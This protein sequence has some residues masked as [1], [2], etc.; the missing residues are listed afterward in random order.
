MEISINKIINK[1]II[2][3]K[4]TF[5]ESNFQVRIQSFLNYASQVLKTIHVR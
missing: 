4:V 3:D 2:V 5:A 1:V